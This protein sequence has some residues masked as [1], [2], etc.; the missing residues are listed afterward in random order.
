M[1]GLARAEPGK[2]ARHAAM[3][4]MKKFFLRFNPMRG[5]YPPKYGSGKW[6]GKSLW[7]GLDLN[8]KTALK[9]EK[10]RIRRLDCRLVGGNQIRYFFRPWPA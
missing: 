7:Q 8:I 9:S 10:F 1:A 5:F 4:N 3:G 6:V 2:K